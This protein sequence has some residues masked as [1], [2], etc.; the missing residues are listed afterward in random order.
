MV[1]LVSDVLVWPRTVNEELYSFPEPQIQCCISRGNFLMNNKFQGPTFAWASC[2]TLR[3]DLQC[4]NM[5][6]YFCKM[7]RSELF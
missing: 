5:V 4:F 7:C 6:I 2:K 1:L 3:G